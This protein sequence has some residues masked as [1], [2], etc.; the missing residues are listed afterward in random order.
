[1]LA[2]LVGKYPVFTDCWKTQKDHKNDQKSSNFHMKMCFLP[3]IVMYF[4]PEPS[5]APHK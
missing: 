5:L 1:M 2:H 4:L 3:L